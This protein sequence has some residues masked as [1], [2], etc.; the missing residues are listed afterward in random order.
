MRTF[1]KIG[2]EH[3]KNEI[4]ELKSITSKF[5]NSMKKLK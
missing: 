2:L 3:K 5:R 1:K 4:M